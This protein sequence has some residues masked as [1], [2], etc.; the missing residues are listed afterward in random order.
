MTEL[1]MMW[2]EDN[3]ASLLLYFTLLPTLPLVRRPST[4]LH[5]FNMLLMLFRLI[6]CLYLPYPT[7][8][9]LPIPYLIYTLFTATIF[10]PPYPLPKLTLPP[11]SNQQNIGVATLPYTL[12]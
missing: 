7:L 5:P 10:M 6:I 11:P 4:P 9:Y 8:P 2:R 12:P 1:G 3:V